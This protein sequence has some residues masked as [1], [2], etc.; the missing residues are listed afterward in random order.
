MAV[1]AAAAGVML[2]AVGAPLNRRLV[3]VMSR[4]TNDSAAVTKSSG[5]AG[6]PVLPPAGA[7]TADVRTPVAVA[8]GKAATA[9]TPGALAIEAPA[10]LLTAV[11][12]AAGAATAVAGR[13]G[14]LN[15]V[16]ALV[17]DTSGSDLAAC[18]GVLLAALR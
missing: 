4:L 11:T 10:A 12:V 7:A 14:G 3:R 15:A 13:A 1:V 9:G 17:T 16:V 6:V 5:P 8:V 18:A 2:A